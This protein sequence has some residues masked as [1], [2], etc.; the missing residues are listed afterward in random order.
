V[1]AR[2]GEGE[3]EGGRQA[4]AMPWFA[5][6]CAGPPRRLPLRRR[7]RFVIIGTNKKRGCQG[8]KEREREREKVEGECAAHAQLVLVNQ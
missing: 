6:K 8:S 7:P 4:P 5:R 2:E 1:R 3:R